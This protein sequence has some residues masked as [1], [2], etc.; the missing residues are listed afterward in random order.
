MRRV[1]DIHTL[2]LPGIDDGARDLDESLR[3]CALGRANH[4][5]KTVATPHFNALGDVDNF[6][7]MRNERAELLRDA[8]QK[9]GIDMKIYTGAEVY[10]DDDIF[11]SKN[12]GRLS[13]NGSRYILIEF[14]FSGLKLRNI[15][16]YLNEIYSMGLVPIIAHPERYEYFQRDYNAVNELASRGVLFQINAASLASRDG[17]EEF[18]LAYEMAFKGV[19]SFIA[20]D[21]HS[22]Y[23]RPNDLAEMLRAFPDD[24]DQRLMQKM[25]H[26]NAEKVL[27]NE[28]LPPLK[29]RYLEKRRFY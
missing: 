3:L 7:E 22:V 20:T 21:A 16:E 23:G 25:L 11:Y 8:V 14:S 6:I 26:S 24:I 17:R 9:N 13:I 18:E 27:L 19:A 29:F 15:L 1:F 12:L 10:I 4:I 2:I 5:R 28:K